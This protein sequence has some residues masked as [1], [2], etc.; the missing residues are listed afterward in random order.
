MICK[1]N[2]NG[3]FSQPK[4]LLHLYKGLF[5][6]GEFS[7]LITGC[8]ST[9]VT[10]IIL[11]ISMVCGVRVVRFRIHSQT[12][13]RAK[14]REAFSDCTSVVVPKRTLSNISIC[15]CINNRFS[16]IQYIVEYHAWR[17][18]RCKNSQKLRNFAVPQMAK[19]SRNQP[20]SSDAM[21]FVTVVILLQSASAR[22][23]SEING[24]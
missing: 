18:Q 21:Q 22:K 5:R 17:L 6:Q 1:R 20:H 10:A 9:N 15:L 3:K 7:R 11:H 14:L 2:T 23:A 16:I 24:R 4:R 12:K 13:K 8:K 19:S